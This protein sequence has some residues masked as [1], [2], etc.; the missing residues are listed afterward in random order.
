MEYLN[1]PVYVLIKSDVRELKKK[2]LLLF[3]QN[4]LIGNMCII[5]VDEYMYNSCLTS[6]TII[7]ILSK[8][9]ENGLHN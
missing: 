8:W 4:A 2:Q 1:N 3:V 7:F 9:N 6:F 5:V